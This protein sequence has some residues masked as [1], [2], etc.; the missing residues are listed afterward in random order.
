[1]IAGRLTGRIELL[2]IANAYAALGIAAALI[3]ILAAKNPSASAI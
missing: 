2:G 3:A 1:M